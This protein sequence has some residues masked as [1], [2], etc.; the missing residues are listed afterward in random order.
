[1]DKNGKI[2]LL[3][4]LADGPLLGDGAMGTQ[5]MIAGLEQG[6]CGEAW[7]LT[8]PEKVR[9][10]VR[11]AEEYFSPG[12]KGSSAMPHKRN[13]VLS[14]NLSGLA[15]LLRSYSIAALEDVALWHERDIS[16]SSVE[17]II[18]PDATILLD[19]MLVR[20]SK[21][22]DRLL[23]Y[24]E[25]MLANLNMTRGLIFSQMV[26]LKLIERERFG[27][28]HIPRCSAMPCGPDRKGRISRSS[29]WAMRRSWPV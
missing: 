6:N 20:F 8:H 12:Q 14:E 10:E 18:A 4:A 11:E 15:R 2:R 24:P 21:L 7:N 1:M 27:K 28:K 19:F 17:K 29:S 3:D 23:I 9:T 5:L 16:H 13:P 22:V 25:R 26:L